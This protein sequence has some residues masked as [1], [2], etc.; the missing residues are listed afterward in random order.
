MIDL[1]TIMKQFIVSQRILEKNRTRILYTK[2]KS[3]TLYIQHKGEMILY[4]KY[5]KLKHTKKVHGGVLEE[6][7]H[8]IVRDDDDI[9]YIADEDGAFV[10]DIF[11]HG[12]IPK[13]Q[14]I[15]VNNRYHNILSLYSWAQYQKDQDKTPVKDFFNV[16]IH[17]DDIERIERMYNTKIKHLQLDILK[18]GDI[19]VFRAYDTIGRKDISMHTYVQVR[20]DASR[21]NQEVRPEVHFEVFELPFEPYDKFEKKIILKVQDKDLWF[22]I[23]HDNSSSTPSIRLED[24]IEKA[25]QILIDDK[26]NYFIILGN[27]L[28]DTMYTDASRAIIEV[29]DKDYLH[30]TRGSRKEIFKYNIIKL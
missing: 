8:K 16:R 22:T 12:K 15:F 18:K 1:K 25:A 10:Y 27:K 7:K 28:L 6:S 14:A 13:S 4:S 11:D 3:S 19:L 29:A 30:R 2:P 24:D 26:N 23:D 20:L 5:K 9:E 17:E 21:K